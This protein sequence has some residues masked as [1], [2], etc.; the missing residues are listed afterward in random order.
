[1]HGGYINNYFTK[2]THI[3]IWRNITKKVIEDIKCRSMNKSTHNS[4]TN[5]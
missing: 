4:N 5:P 1:M 2:K 3:Y